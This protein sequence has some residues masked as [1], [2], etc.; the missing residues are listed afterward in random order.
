[1]PAPQAK[2]ILSHPQS[3]EEIFKFYHNF[4]TYYHKWAMQ[5]RFTYWVLLLAS[6]GCGVATAWY[7]FKANMHVV[8]ALAIALNCLL[9]INNAL[10]PDRKYPRYRM[11]EMRLRFELQKMHHSVARRIKNGEDS[12]SALLAELDAL[13][14]KVESLVLGE[15]GEYFRDFVSIKD[16]HG[17]LADTER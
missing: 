14:P 11:V 12:E 9:I 13:H 16:F 6:L 15:F 1:V 4:V 10:G 3:A 5:H 7:L 17:Q 2:K 8:A